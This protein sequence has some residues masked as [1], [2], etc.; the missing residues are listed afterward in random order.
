MNPTRITTA[1]FKNQISD[2]EI[3][4]FRGAMI[5]L[6]GDDAL[7]H[8]HNVDG[9]NYMYPLVQYKRIKGA[10]AVVGIN[11][12]AEVVERLFATESVFPCQLGNRNVE[13]KLASIRTESLFSCCD[14]SDNTY[15]IRYW[16]PLNSKNYKEYQRAEGLIERIAMLEKILIGNVLSFGKGIGIHFEF[17]VTCHILELEN[18]GLSRYKEVELMSFSAVFQCN[19]CL[20]ENVGLGKSS[21]VGY[22]IVNC[23]E[24]VK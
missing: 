22:G 9:F 7:F 13:L 6:S 16:L 20:P 5:R 4:F 14:E 12:G 18:P 3:P 23:T 24:K 10:A 15:R 11:Q 21:S 19:V 1:L 2:E 8:N 17:P